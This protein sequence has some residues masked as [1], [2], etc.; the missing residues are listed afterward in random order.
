MD[1]LTAIRL[2]MDERMADA[3]I[4]AS[5]RCE[6][7]NVV[8]FFS[9]VHDSMTKY[10]AWSQILRNMTMTCKCALNEG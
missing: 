2:E 4:R 9:M 8:Y 5:Q 6:L 7:S 10:E 1:D 3:A